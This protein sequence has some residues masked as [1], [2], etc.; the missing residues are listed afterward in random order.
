MVTRIITLATFASFLVLGQLHAEEEES[1]LH[2]KMEEVNRSLKLLRRAGEDY[3]K[4]A[5]LVRQAQTLMLECFAFVPATIEK[6]PE[7]KERNIAWANYRKTM[8][9]SYQTL[10]DLE[11]AYISGD[12]DQIDDAMDEVKGLRKEGH[13]EYIEENA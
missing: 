8:A 10:C 9:Q 13:E 3:E 12:L 6:M 2:E 5:G 7:G 4:A 11:L 1:P